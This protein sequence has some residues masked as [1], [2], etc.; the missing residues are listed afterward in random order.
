MAVQLTTL[1]DGG[2]S[3]LDVAGEVA[4]FLN[5]ATTSLE[6]ALY[7]VRFETTAGGLV[8][9]S[10]LAA[11]QR[12]VAVRLLYNVDHPGPIPVPPPVTRAPIAKMAANARD[13]ISAR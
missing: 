10:L 13:T 5:D 9:A 4:S 1:A 8:L 2:Q 7:D 11:S 6:L 3:A 12:G